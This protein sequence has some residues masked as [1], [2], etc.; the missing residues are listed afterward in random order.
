VPAA[1]DR[2]AA[3]TSRDVAV[4]FLETFTQAFAAWIEKRLRL[5]PLPLAGEGW[6]GGFHKV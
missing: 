3:V 5:L 4:I 2:Q 6:L 1:L